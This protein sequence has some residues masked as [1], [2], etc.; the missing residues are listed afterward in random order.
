MELILA[1]LF[2]YNKNKIMKSLII[3]KMREI[4]DETSPTFKK[5]LC[6]DLDISHMTLQKYLNGHVVK[7]DIA[8]AIIN[9]YNKNH[10]G[11]QIHN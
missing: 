1:P 10:V 9:Y 11:T 3:A 2:F 6:V 5:Q 8:D 4:K 7:I